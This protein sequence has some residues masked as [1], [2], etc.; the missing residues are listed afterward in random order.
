MSIFLGTLLFMI[1]A[2]PLSAIAAAELLQ[3]TLKAAQNAQAQA[4]QN[5]SALHEI[6]ETLAD[7]SQRMK[8]IEEAVG[9]PKPSNQK[10]VNQIV[11]GMKA[12]THYG[13]KSTQP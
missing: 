11:D 4:Q 10:I 13:F 12:N 3:I 1:P 2:E 7:L 6:Q 8:R 5:S 9:V